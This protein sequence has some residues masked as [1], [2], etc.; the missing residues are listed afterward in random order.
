MKGPA[1]TRR[2][3]LP[4]RAR[5]AT[6]LPRRAAPFPQRA[7]PRLRKP[8]R[9]HRAPRLLTAA[10]LLVLLVLSAALA[11]GCGEQPQARGGLKV[12]ATTGFLRDI[13]QHVAADRFTVGQLMPDGA[14]PHAFEPAPSDLR[15]V[16]GADLLIVNGAGLEGALLDTARQAG[17]EATV[18]EASAGIRTR[19]PKPGEPPLAAGESDPHFWMDPTLV[20][21]YVLAICD[22]YVKADPAGTAAYNR[23][24]DDY[25]RELRRLDS[26]IAAKVGQVPENERVLV[27]AH[28]S[29]GYFADRYGIRIAGTIVPGVASSDTPTA[30]QLSDLVTAIR[31]TG[32]RA[33]VI[34]AG[35][36][37][38]LA[39]QVGAE[40]G[41]PVIDD[42][43][44]HALTSADGPAPTY[45][46]M[47]RFNT[48]RLVEA[49]KR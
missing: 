47:M 26:W 31:H 20:A 13:A 22:A 16:A 10:V 21:R 32:A 44:D 7:A 27:T 33:I 48:L 43:R 11:A 25:R 23:A 42:L 1:T 12:V 6:L 3:T 5:E 28:S 2:A 41:I 36:N 29:L 45:I 46:D 4:G 35:E 15:A 24:A 30:R 38:T 18:V 37:P 17:S 34:D 9:P 39:R 40:T 14:D 49:M 19:T 8:W